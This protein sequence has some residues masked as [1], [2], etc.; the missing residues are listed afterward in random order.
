MADKLIYF[1]IYYLLMGVIFS[2]SDVSISSE[3]K[4]EI[5]NTVSL[6]IL[7]NYLVERTEV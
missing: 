3:S 6:T 4:D 1:I 7:E 5:I 2:Q